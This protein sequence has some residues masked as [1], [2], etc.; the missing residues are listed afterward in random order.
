MLVLSE[1][2]DNFSIGQIIAIKREF[3]AKQEENKKLEQKNS[4]LISHLISITN[5]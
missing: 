3:K 1:S 4:D 2:F 5:F